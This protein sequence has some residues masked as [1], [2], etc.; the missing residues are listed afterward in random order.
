MN[1]EAIRA[2]ARTFAEK[3]RAATGFDAFP[4][5][6]PADL[7]TA[8]AMQ[9]AAMAEWDRPLAGWKIG[10]IAGELAEQTGEN[11]FVGPVFT[12][13][14]QAADMA[15]S[16]AF[17]AIPAGFAA[18]EA[19]LVAVVGNAESR[20]DWTAEA[21]APAIA[22]WHIGI[23][24]AGSPYAGIQDAGALATIAGFGNNIG[25]I[26]GP[27]VAIA[28]PAAMVAAVTIDGSEVARK[29][30]SELPGGPLAAVAFALNRLHRMG[31]ALPAGTLLS[32][33]AITG[34]HAV[35]PGQQCS[36]AFAQGGTI[37]CTVIP[38]AAGS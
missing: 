17:P 19:E 1:D 5:A 26:L 3:R 37:A 33:G 36:A 29:A 24:V 27:K 31:I 35:T 21:C 13:S 11:R 6:M 16:T 15:G 30:A 8:Y 25:L 38:L 22:A 9:A 32:T 7:A 2:V 28:D 10:R 20:D 18:L 34:V 23:E 4:G 14:V 12:D